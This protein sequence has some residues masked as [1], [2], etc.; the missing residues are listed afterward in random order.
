[1]RN[2]K[3][4]FPV[5]FSETSLAGLKIFPVKIHYRRHSVLEVI[6]IPGSFPGVLG[7]RDPGF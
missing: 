5:F 7:Q 6:R 4:G 1:M 2:H 3:A